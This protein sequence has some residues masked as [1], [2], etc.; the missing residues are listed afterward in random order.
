MPRII[1]E[2]LVNN[3]KYYENA[4]S[5]MNGSNSGMDLTDMS[6]EIISIEDTYRETSAACRKSLE[7]SEIKPIVKGNKSMTIIEEEDY[8]ESEILAMGNSTLLG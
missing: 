3:N 8:E 7:E 1:K 2:P 4:G 6:E 5:P